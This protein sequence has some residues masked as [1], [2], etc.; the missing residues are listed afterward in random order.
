MNFKKI[1]EVLK[2]KSL[3]LLESFKSFY[4]LLREF[5]FSEA[6]EFKSLKKYQDI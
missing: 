1:A 5:K 2:I 4:D 6:L 3:S